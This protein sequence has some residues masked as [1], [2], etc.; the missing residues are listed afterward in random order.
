MHCRI[1]NRV[2]LKFYMKND[3]KYW[4]ILLLLGCLALLNALISTWLKPFE[5]VHHFSVINIHWINSIILIA[6]LAPFM[7]PQKTLKSETAIVTVNVLSLCIC[8]SCAFADLGNLGIKVFGKPNNTGFFSNFISD[9]EIETEIPY[10]PPEIA[11]HLAEMAQRFRN[12]LFVYNCLDLVI[13]VLAACISHKLIVNRIDASPKLHLTD[14]RRFQGYGVALI[15][16]TVTGI[17]N[18]IW[19]RMIMVN[20][21]QAIFLDMHTIDE[22]SW[23]V[24]NL[25]TGILVF[26]SSQANQ[27]VQTTSFILS[28][29]TIYPS[30]FYAWLDYRVMTSAHSKFL[31]RQSMVSLMISIPHMFV[32]LTIF[33][34]FI[35]SR[36]D[37]TRVNPNPSEQKLPFLTAFL[38]LFTGLSVASRFNYITIAASLVTGI[39]SIN[40][41]YLHIFSYVYLQVNG[42]FIDGTSTEFLVLPSDKYDNG[43]E[44]SSVHSIETSLNV[45]SLIGSSVLVMFLVYLART[46]FPPPDNSEDNSERIVEKVKHER[47]VLALGVIMLVSALLVLLLAFYVFFRITSPHP[48]VTIYSQL[49]HI[50][51]ALS[52][53]S[54]ALFQV[55]VAEHLNRYPILSCALVIL[56]II[57]ALDILTQIDY[58]DIGNQPFTWTVHAV[59][60]YL[61]MFFHFATIA[62]VFELKEPEDRSSSQPRSRYPSRIRSQ[63]RPTRTGTSCFAP[64]KRAG[65]VIVITHCIVIPPKISPRVAKKETLI[66]LS[67]SLHFLLFSNP[68]MAT[69]GKDKVPACK[70]STIVNKQFMTI[71]MIGKGGYGV[72]YEVIRLDSPTSRFA[73]KAELAVA[74]NNLKTEWDLMTLL[75]DNKSRHNISGVELGAERNY[76]Y[77]VMHLVGPSLA[78]LRKATTKK[79]FTLFTT[80]VCGIQCF[81]SL[82][83]LH[84]LG[85]IHRDV[86]PGNF[87]IGVLGSEEEKLVYILDFGLCRNMF[88]KSKELRK[89]RMK[90]PFRGTIPYCSMNIHNRM[91]PGRHDDFWSLL[92]M[93]I[94]FQLGDLPWDNMSKEETKKTKEKKIEELLSKCPTEFKMFR[95]YLLTLC[96]SKEPE[97]PK[98]RGILCQIML[99]NKF[100]SDMPLDW[101][102]G[103]EYES[104]FKPRAAV[105]RH[106]GSKNKVSLADLLDLPQPGGHIYTEL[107]FPKPLDQEVPRDE[108]VSKSDDTI[109][110]KDGPPPAPPPL[111]RSPATPAPRLSTENQK[112]NA[113][114]ATAPK[115]NATVALKPTRGS[116]DPLSPPVKP[117]NAN[118]TAIPKP[119]TMPAPPAKP[120]LPAVSCAAAV[121]AMPQ[122]PPPPVT[123]KATA[124]AMPQPP[125]K[126]APSIAQPPPPPLPKAPLVSTAG[127]VTAVPQAPTKGQ[128]K[129]LPGKGKK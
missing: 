121:T 11:D 122:P 81:D 113:A 92:Y 17:V 36:R 85:Y 14:N 103:G 21:K 23:L 60:E 4:Y 30:F 57:R 26:L 61:A 112:G 62:I 6:G 37:A 58:K 128:N 10:P 8:L 110:E 9:D 102:S 89:P 63:T 74:H 45:M 42:Y 3:R 82:V 59:I 91:E 56:S 117:M 38:A 109:I 123:T 129:P 40:A 77:I 33:L 97:Y 93:L 41:T 20:H 49:F 53:T 119:P 83:E 64:R 86:K 111:A 15:M 78:D 95:C 22:F 125:T 70:L 35:M 118:V 48:L 107:D 124:T 13:C 46:A 28:G 19:Q 65:F 24:I 2:V 87:A 108:S 88:N 96:Y 84:K 115:P 68:K 18:H 71:Q 80:T 69:K 73:C 67:R 66:N 43:T 106:K 116:A 50:V 54:Y 98:L 120:S 75:R 94:E 101:Q 72:V 105:V 104:I 100:T 79:T 44:S 12:H 90:A 126:I 29:A 114:K 127:A 5:L 32:L 51:L 34:T 47:S 52:I 55:L 76:N 31:F 7:F 99:V 16:M 27:I 25:A 1:W 39:L